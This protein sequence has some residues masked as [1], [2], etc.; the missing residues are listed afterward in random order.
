MCF[1]TGIVSTP[2][3]RA[4]GRPYR[5]R[6]FLLKRLLIIIVLLWC[7]HASATCPRTVALA[8]NLTEIV[9]ALGKGDC[10]VGVS[11]GSDYPPEA[12][13]LPQI[14]GYYQNLN[15]ERVLTLKPDLVLALQANERQTP[16]AEKLQKRGLE[17]VSVPS[18]SVADIKAAIRSVGARLEVT[19]QAEAIVAGME[20]DFLGLRERLQKMKMAARPKVALILWRTQ[21]TLQDLYVAGGTGFHNELLQAIGVQNIFGDLTTP[22]PRIAKEA[23]IARN[24]EVIIDALPSHTAEDMRTSLALW[25]RLTPLQAVQKKKI[26]PLALAEIT[27]PGPRIGQVAKTLFETVYGH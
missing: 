15:L 21:G 26:Y 3:G 2:R 4:K 20:R 10:L 7:H 11:E 27:I 6:G 14:G 9:F 5:N 12:K 19:G 16:V 23:L 1:P 22:F 18:E 8:P 25:D 24:P 17:V 13:K